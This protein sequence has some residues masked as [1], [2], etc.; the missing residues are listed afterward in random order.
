MKKAIFGSLVAAIFLGIAIVVWQ[1]GKEERYAREVLSS[2]LKD[3]HSAEIRDLNRL[4]SDVLCGKV[5]SKNSYGAFAGFSRFVI[6]KLSDSIGP[7]V[8]L[9]GEGNLGVA[10]QVF[11]KDC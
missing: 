10:F 6:Y 11:G 1:S 2:V 4:G 9:E 3:A 5:N 8:G 7:K